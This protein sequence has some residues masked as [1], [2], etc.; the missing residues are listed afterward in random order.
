MPKK[1][2]LADDS[3]TIQKVIS[4]TFAAEDYELII[5]GDGDSAI[6]KAKET[7]PDLVMADVAMPGKNG[8]EVCEAVKGDPEIASTPV[9]LLSGTFEPLNE[10]DAARVG[11][12]GHI[13]KPFESEE[14]LGRVRDILA[15]P[16]APAAAPP[17]PPVEAAPPPPPVEAAPPPPPVEAAP[18]PP[19]AEAAPPPPPV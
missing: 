8:Y 1:I 13:V 7:R 3:I 6:A 4:L 11:A 19:P 12:D 18:P 15:K 16:A 10:V 14:L 17:P 5:V 2:L 9:L